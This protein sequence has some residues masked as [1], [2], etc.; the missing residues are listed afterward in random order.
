MTEQRTIRR[1]TAYFRGWAV[2]FGEHEAM[3]DPTHGLQWLLGAHEVGIILTP[4]LRRTL[5]RALLP[6]D[7]PTPKIRITASGF[8]VG[9][10]WFLLSALAPAIAESI[11]GLFRNA[12]DLHLYLTYHLWYP[13]GTRILTLS[14]T[15]PLILIYKEIEPF[16]AEMSLDQAN[17]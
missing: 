2:A 11:L 5:L 13:P 10:H 9:G 14:K 15:K 17:D 16:L 6:K 1:Y 7:Q 12:D 3:D 8:Q 4:S